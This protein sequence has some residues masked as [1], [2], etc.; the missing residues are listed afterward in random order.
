L[1][2][3][4]PT[5]WIFDHD[6]I[7]LCTAVKGHMLCKLLDTDAGKVIYLDPDVALLDDLAPVI[8]LLDTNN[9]VLT[10]HQ[11]EPDTDLSAIIDNEV[12]SLKYGIYNLG[13]LA[14]AGTAEGRRFA[15]WWRDRLHMFCF[16]DV[17][18]GLFTDQRWCDHVPVFFDGVHILRDPGYNVASW[19]L[20]RRPITIEQDGTIRAA[21]Q[22]LRFFHFT[23]VTHVGEIML[24]RYSGGRIEVFELMKWY[25][26]R[27]AS[28]VVS[29]LPK[30]WWAY[31]QYANGSKIE[32]EHRLAYRQD[33]ELRAQYPDPFAAGPRIFR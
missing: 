22:I 16:D 28:H 25:R 27:L 23:K 7:E 15:R 29:G 19:N 12:G 26:D 10:P 33:P 18:N 2:I 31:G 1:D 20:S 11:L 21:G 30:S 9:I 14:V 32:R 6:V 8:S 13:F 24:E 4:D 3:P 5:R 17:P